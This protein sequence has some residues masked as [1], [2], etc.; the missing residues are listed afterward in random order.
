MARISVLLLLFGACALCP[1]TAN[2]QAMAPILSLLFNSLQQQVKIARQRQGVDF[3]VPEPPPNLLEQCRLARLQSCETHFVQTPDGYILELHHI[4][5]AT[6]GAIP[7]L[8]LHGNF[9]TSD[10]FLMRT[11]QPNLATSLHEAG[12]DVWLG[13]W[14]GSFRSKRHVRLNSSDPAFYNFSMQDIGGIDVPTFIDFILDRT[15]QP[16]LHLISH[17]MGCPVTLIALSTRPEYNA[18]VRFAA[19]MAP[20][21]WPRNTLQVLATLLFDVFSNE[22]RAF[23]NLTKLWNLIPRS[24]FFHNLGDL[25]CRDNSPLIETCWWGFELIFGKSHPS[26]RMKEFIPSVLAT[27]PAGSTFNIQTQYAVFSITGR[28]RPLGKGIRDPQ[29]PPDYNLT[30]ITT[31]VGLYYGATDATMAVKDMVRLE[32]ALPVLEDS[33]LV[34]LKH[35]S[36]F[37]FLT[38]TDG[39]S[40]LYDRIIQ[41]MKTADYRTTY[42]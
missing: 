5:P 20:V 37:D 2:G 35:F 15:G 40:V 27:H 17:S 25:M 11:D 6:A 33:Y 29:P 18:K 13:N 23:M 21:I 22:L 4:P 32:R 16:S 3:I 7:V 14:R 19:L 26:Q 12:Y 34:P 31:P 10:G 42:D 24:A 39:R 9:G 8:V 30:A 38:A 36:H 1:S 28:F 41:K